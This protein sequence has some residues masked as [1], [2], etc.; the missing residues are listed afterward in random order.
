MFYGNNLLKI[1]LFTNIIQQ[2]IGQTKLCILHAYIMCDVMKTR[3]V[4]CK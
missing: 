4:R 2:N 3:S 1:T